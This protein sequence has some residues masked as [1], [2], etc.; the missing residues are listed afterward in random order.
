M[1]A[2]ILS[3]GVRVNVTL[4]YD[5]RR[6]GHIDQIRHTVPFDVQFTA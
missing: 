4:K 6:S 3:D 1:E 5:L 2:F